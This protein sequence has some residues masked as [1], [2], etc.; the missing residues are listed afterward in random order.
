MND[1]LPVETIRSETVHVP[2]SRVAMFGWLLVPLAVLAAAVWWL[3]AADPL[4]AFDNGAPPVENL[5]VERTVLD[6]SGMRM[7]VRVG[8]S[9]PMNI[10]QVQ[11]DAA[12]WEFVQEPSG[13][14]DRGQ[15]AWI[16][17]PFPWVVGEAHNVTFVTN[18]GATFAH[19]IPVAVATPEPTAAN[20]YSQAILGAFVGILPVAIGLAF[21]PALRG[22]GPNVM[23][24]LL[25]LTVG[26][27]GFL[28]LDTLEDAFSFAA[29]SAALFQG[30]AMVVLAASATF[31][32][33]MAVGRR[34]G[35]PVGVALSTYIAIGIGLHNFGEGLAIGAA[36]AAGAS[37]LGTFLV[38][39]FTLHNITEGIGI[40]AP[41]LHR[42][43]PLATFVGLALLAGG[44]AV[45]GMWIG[46]L[47]YAPQWSALFLAIGAGAIAQVI[48]EVAALLIRRRGRGRPATAL[49]P[50]ILSGLAIG[51]GFMYL[52]AMLVKF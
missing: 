27:L 31:L 12:Y 50:A 32:V 41:I 38:V 28:F 13:A 47:A 4:A 18:T 9:E 5:T 39:G 37:G 44:P 1:Q 21:Y 25:A 10:A 15:S 17:I 34:S 40:A 30:A 8:G 33:L 26:L 2:P 48:V 14:L 52:T 29:Q 45:V 49:H 3:V 23:D 43:P 20:L 46:S 22:A 36:F 7:L 24:F 11:V 42:R 6:A 51:V 35:A 16:D 19:E